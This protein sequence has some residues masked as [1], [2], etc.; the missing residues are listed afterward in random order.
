MTYQDSFTTQL[1]HKK[2]EGI[3]LIDVRERG[4]DEAGH[5]AGTVNLPLNESV[6]REDE[7]GPHTL[8]ICASGNRSSQAAAYLA[9]L[10]KT[11]LMK[12]S[13]GAA[14]WVREERELTRGEQP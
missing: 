12:L 14:A 7:I 2:R 10:D 13:G 3:C 1:E 5:V 6:G 11:G 4:E 9:S 8:L